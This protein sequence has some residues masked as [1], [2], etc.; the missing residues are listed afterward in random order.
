MWLSRRAK[1]CAKSKMSLTILGE[2]LTYPLAYIVPRKPTLN[3]HW[4]VDIINTTWSCK[5][6]NKGCKPF[7]GW[8]SPLATIQVQIGEFSLI[9]YWNSLALPYMVIGQ[10]QWSWNTTTGQGNTVSFIHQIS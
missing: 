6:M 5:P 4:P 3:I 1:K 7:G 10:P 2:E 8:E 9:W